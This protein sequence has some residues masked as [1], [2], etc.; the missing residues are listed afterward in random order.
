MDQFFSPRGKRVHILHDSKHAARV[1]LGVAHGKKNIALANKCNDLVLRSKGRFRM[2]VHHVFRHAGNAKNE[3]A[4]TAAGTTFFYV[5]HFLF[6][7]AEILH[8]FM[9]GLQSE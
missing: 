9:G 4:D 3:R 8:N 1:V 6:Q 5:S 7:I 2:S